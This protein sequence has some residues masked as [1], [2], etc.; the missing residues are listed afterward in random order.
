M[1]STRRLL[2]CGD[3]PEK[4]FD[5]AYWLK[6]AEEARTM[7]GEMTTHL[8]QEAMLRIAAQYER[9]AEEAERRVK[10]R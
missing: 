7:A 2:E 9:L 10:P 8:N 3:L 1:S 6:M 4:E 5:A